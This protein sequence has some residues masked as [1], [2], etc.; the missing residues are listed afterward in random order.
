MLNR[1]HR[2]KAVAPSENVRSF[3]FGRSPNA[4]TRPIVQAQF[5]RSAA[6]FSFGWYSLPETM[7]KRAKME[8][9]G[10]QTA[11]TI[12]AGT[13]FAPAFSLFVRLFLFGRDLLACFRLCVGFLAYVL[14][15]CLARLLG[16]LGLLG[17]FPCF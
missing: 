8:K 9:I 2:K 15:F 3:V 7:R 5:V 17:C 1:T 11:H 4:R 13:Q 6:F 12:K 14:A 16:L 10:K